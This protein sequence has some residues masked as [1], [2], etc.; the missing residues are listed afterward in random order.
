ML[1][2]SARLLRL[3]SLLETRR[4][5]TGPQLAERLGVT[6]R[7]I[8]NDMERLRSLGYPVDATPGASGGY[9]LGA[10][11][12]L[13]PLL[14]DDD[15][16]V[17]VAIGLRTAA[18]GAVA[19]IEHSS[20]R[21]LAKLQPVL[22]SRLRRRIGALAAA[23]V[24]LPGSGPSVDADTLTAIAGA[25]RDHDRLRFDY[26][27]HDGAGRVRMTEPH[28]LVTSGRR[29]YLLAWDLDRGDW[30]TFRVDRIGLRLPAGPRF[31]PRQMPDDEVTDRLS[32]GLATATWRYRA[33][34]TVH[35]S[36]A[37]IAGRLPAVITAEPVS[38]NTCVIE[39][40]SDTPAM[41]ALYLGLLDA[42]FQIDE[43][44]APELA[45]CLRTLS[46]RYARA[47]YRHEH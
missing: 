42:D 41:L 1:A 4:D 9:R 2:T 27:T 39:V 18:S 5:W 16:A 36:A 44:A 45:E 6:T 14:L 35:A 25:C 10:G 40:G 38:Q 23:M 28:R 31:A 24:T 8:R 21:A 12:A 19:G 3:L 22:P 11:A 7:T 17:A 26:H 15:E 43:S 30:R 29:W 33:R 32:R 46:A 47:T 20:V 37:Q 34:V 13:P